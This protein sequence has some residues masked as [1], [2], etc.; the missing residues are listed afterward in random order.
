MSFLERLGGRGN[1]DWQQ[2]T[3]NFSDLRRD[4][5]QHLQLVYVTL[6]ATVLAAAFGAW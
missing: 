3:K 4:V 5:Q 1:F 6:A 2:A